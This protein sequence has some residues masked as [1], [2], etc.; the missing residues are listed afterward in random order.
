MTN[1]YGPLKPVHHHSDESQPTAA[2][3]A[4]VVD[5]FEAGCLRLSGSEGTGKE[6]AMEQGHRKAVYWLTSLAAVIS[7]LVGIPCLLE[8]VKPRTTGAYQ[9]DR[10]AQGAPDQVEVTIGQ[11][12]Q[13]LGVQH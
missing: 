6:A 5:S 3:P 7:L 12:I 4:S 2:D 1:I 9:L 10:A 13:A 8:S 11:A